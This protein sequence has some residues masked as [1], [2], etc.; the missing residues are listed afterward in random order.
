MSR[1]WLSFVTVSKDDAPGLSRTLASAAGWRARGGVEQIVVYAGAEPDALPEGVQGL[2]QEGE[3]IA[4]AFNEGLRVARGEWVWFL[5]GGDA[6]HEEIS[7]DWMEALLSRTRADLVVGCIH[8]DGD[9]GPRVLAPL[10]EQWPPLHC[11]LPHPATLVRRQVLIGVGGFSTRYRAC[12]DF[13]LWQRLL[14][15]GARADVVR[16]SFAR[17]DLRGLS[18]RS[19]N[20]GLLFRENGV[21]LWRHQGVVWRAILRSAF[22]LLLAWLRALRHWLS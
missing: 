21:V 14:G 16:M 7:P 19:E 15:A 11:W 22:G 1:V 4:S 13:D 6:L 2:R 17:F 12:M 3:G 18:S 5:N 9:A 10:H 20:V 8:A